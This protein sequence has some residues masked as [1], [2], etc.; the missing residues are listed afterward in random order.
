MICIPSYK[1]ANDCVAAQYIKSATIFCH[2]FE[3]DEY[4][5]YNDNPIIVIPDDLKGK[6]MGIIRNYILDNAGVDEILM[7][8]D[9][10]KSVGYYEGGE[11]IE[12]TGE[13]VEIFAKDMFRLAR[14]AGTIVWGVNMQSDKKFYREYS[15]FSLSSC[16]LGPFMGIINDKDLRFDEKLGLKED[17]DFS[18]Q[19]LRKYRKILRFNKYHYIASHI[20]KKGGCASYRTQDKEIQQAEAFQRK[21]GSRIVKIKRKTQGGNLSINPVVIVPIRGI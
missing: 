4:R 9:D 6:G 15:P 18:I 5:K 13:E 11:R 2:E 17:Y 7:V 10:V 16:V 12:L 21:W 3:A 14:E 8:D 1:R 20:E 19:V